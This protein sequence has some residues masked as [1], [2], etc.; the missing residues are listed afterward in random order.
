M[1]DEQH[2]ILDEGCCQQMMKQERMIDDVHHDVRDDD[3]LMIPYKDA[4]LMMNDVNLVPVL[5]VVVGC[6]DDAIVALKNYGEDNV[7]QPDGDDGG[8][9]MTGDDDYLG[10]VY[11]CCWITV[12]IHLTQLFLVMI[13]AYSAAVVKVQHVQFYQ[14]Q[15]YY[16]YLHPHQLLSF[17]LFPVPALKLLRTLISTSLYALLLTPFSHSAESISHKAQILCYLH[18]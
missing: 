2:S 1:D 4:I 17:H 14:N 6:V 11:D 8:Y 12:L 7:E 3:D 10:L 5:T 15:L 18:L 13:Y 16:Q 9:L